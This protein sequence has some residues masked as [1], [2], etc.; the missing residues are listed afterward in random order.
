MYLVASD[1]RRPESVLN[2]QIGGWKA[3]RAVLKNTVDS[4]AD[5][6]AVREQLARQGVEAETWRRDALE[7][8]ETAVTAVL[9]I[10]REL[11]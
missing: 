7:S 5:H 11:A 9:P 4:L 8:L 6:F 1:A 3:V 10:L 2:Q